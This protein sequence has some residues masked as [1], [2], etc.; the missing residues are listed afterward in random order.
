VGGPGRLTGVEIE[1]S[2][3]GC[4]A[5]RGGRRGAGEKFLA[6]LQQIAITLVNN[7]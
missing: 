5:W 7:P 2:Q 4:A 6:G 1:D 3:I